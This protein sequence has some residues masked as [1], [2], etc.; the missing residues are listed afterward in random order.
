M[1]ARDKPQSAAPRN[2]FKTS[3]LFLPR[4][5]RYG[6]LALEQLLHGVDGI[7]RDVVEAGGLFVY[8]A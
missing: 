2:G 3:G 1:R 7:A 4:L 6:D 8:N 5:L